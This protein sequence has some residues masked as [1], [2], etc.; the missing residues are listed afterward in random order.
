VKSSADLPPNIREKL[1]SILE[2]NMFGALSMIN[3]RSQEEE[4]K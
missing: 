4:A 3:P 2:Q 1:F